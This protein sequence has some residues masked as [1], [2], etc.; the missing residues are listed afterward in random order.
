[1]KW[2]V[3]SVA[4]YLLCLQVAASGGA[5]AARNGDFLVAIWRGA[6]ASRNLD[7]A[8]LSG[9][10]LRPRFLTRVGVDDHSPSWSPDGRQIVFA[11]RGAAR[12]GIY[13]LR[14]STTIRLTHG[15]GDAAPAYSPDGTRIAFSRAPPP[16][17]TRTSRFAHLVVMR[18]DG[19]GGR[20]VVRTRYR[21]RQINWSPDGRRLF[22]SDDGVLRT[23]EVAS[24]AVRQLGVGGLRPTLSQDGSR[25]AYLAP[26]EPGPFY[27]DLNWGIYVADS[28]GANPL[29]VVDGQFGPLSWSP[30][31]ER[32]LVTDGRSLALVDIQ[33]GAMR[34]LGLAGSG[35]AFKP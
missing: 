21:T 9:D 6:G 27:R 32:L 8:L 24:G 30:D 2:G 19:R 11:R 18:A 7:L 14:G 1:M 20:V 10:A 29:R 31:G 4:V 12:G 26:G 28:A 13:V 3:A 15:A 22:Y 25:I 33:S 5:A 35:G 17:P 16:D 23:V 34:P